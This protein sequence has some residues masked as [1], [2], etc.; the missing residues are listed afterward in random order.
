MKHMQTLIIN[1]NPLLNLVHTGAMTPGR[2]NRVPSMAMHAEGKGVNVARVLARLGHDVVLTGFGGGH[3]GAWLRELVR[4]DGIEDAF[5]D[6]A[7]PLRVGFMASCGEKEH[8]TTVLPN[9]FPVTAKECAVLAQRVAGLLERVQLVIISGSA[10]D[11]SANGLYAEILS[12]CWS[13]GLPCWL[14]AHGMALDQALTGAHPPDLA[15]PNREEYAQSRHWQGVAELHITDGAGP[16][17]VHILNAGGWRVTP[18]VIRQVNPVGSGD[19]YLAGLA[20]G[21][22][23]GWPVEERLRFACAAG[24]A[25]ALRQD[26]ALID[27]EAIVARLGEVI[28]ERQA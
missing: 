22:L 19:C 4:A 20:H 12:L 17:E 14:D 3:S 10:P 11:P 18:P 15:K 1:T 2:I 25:N 7:A 26:V 8:P 5:V 21:W 16:V 24:A 6:S 13:A 28:V 9:G 23:S 27:P